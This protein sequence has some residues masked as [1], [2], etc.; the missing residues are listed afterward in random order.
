MAEDKEY[1]GTMKLGEITD[2]QDADGQ[3]TETREVQQYTGEQ[4]DADFATND[5]EF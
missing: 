1:V 4:I 2:S 3:V 5:G